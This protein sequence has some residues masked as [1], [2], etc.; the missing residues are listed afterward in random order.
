MGGHRPIGVPR[1]DPI[2]GMGGHR[3]VGVPWADPIAGMGSHRPVGVPQADPIA[4]MGSHPRVGAPPTLRALAV[5][6]L[7]RARRR[8]V[9]PAPPQGG[10]GARSAGRRWRSWRWRA[11]K[12]SRPPGSGASSSRDSR[13]PPRQRDAGAAHAD[14]PD[15]RLDLV[16]GG[17]SGRWPRHSSPLRASGVVPARAT[18]AADDPGRQA[19]PP[20]P[21]RLV[22]RHHVVHAHVSADPDEVREGA[23]PRDLL[24][25][26]HPTPYEQSTS[27]FGATGRVASLA[28]VSLLRAASVVQARGIVLRSSAGLPMTRQLWYFDVG[29]H[30]GDPL[31]GVRNG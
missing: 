2:A 10:A 6:P 18:S 19:L 17:L 30:G 1:A 31:G 7:P 8:S 9:R 16:P 24:L 15:A 14:P 20:A 27:P 28:D 3:P 26:V 22:G 29:R 5:D 13:P 23:V 12:A 11:R 4:G 21:G 25:G